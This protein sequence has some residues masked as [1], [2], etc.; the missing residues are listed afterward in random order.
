LAWLLLKGSVE[1]RYMLINLQDHVTENTRGYWQQRVKIAEYLINR[2]GLTD[3]DLVKILA[4]TPLTNSTGIAPNSFVRLVS[5]YIALTDIILSKGQALDDLKYARLFAQIEDYALTILNADHHALKR[6]K[7]AARE[8]NEKLYGTKE[9]KQRTW[10]KYQ[11]EV[12]RL[13][14]LHPSWSY[15][16]LCKAVAKPFKKHKETIKRH[17]YNPCKPRKK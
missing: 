14:E 5:Y 13:H 2:C 8:N 16:R 17:T 12:N 6:T 3:Q 11:E 10:G 9:E 1:G 4:S 15:E 7:E